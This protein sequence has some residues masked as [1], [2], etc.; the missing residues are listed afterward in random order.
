MNHIEAV[1]SLQMLY[2][3]TYT[4]ASLEITTYSDGQVQAKCT[5]YVDGL[6]HHSGPTW[7]DAFRS[8]EAAGRT[9]EQIFELT[10]TGA[11]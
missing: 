6:K 9:S 2:P 7:E 8:L 1:K 11:I 10:E 4:S 5:V 3:E